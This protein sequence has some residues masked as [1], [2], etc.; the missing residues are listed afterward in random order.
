MGFWIIGLLDKWRRFA[1]QNNPFIHQ[2][3]NPCFRRRRGCQKLMP[4]NSVPQQLTPTANPM[5]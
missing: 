2:S 1:I 4:K 3:T 5:L